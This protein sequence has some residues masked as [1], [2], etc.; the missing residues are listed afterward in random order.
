MLTDCW[1]AEVWIL[2]E[3]GWI[4]WF[5]G[6]SV[7]LWSHHQNVAKTSQLLECSVYSI[8]NIMI[9]RHLQHLLTFHKEFIAF[10]YLKCRQLV[11]EH[12]YIRQRQQ[13]LFYDGI[14]F[15]FMQ[16]CPVLHSHKSR[17]PIFVVWLC[18]WI[19]ASFPGPA[20]LSVASLLQA[21]K[22]WA[23]PG[24]EANWIHIHLHHAY[25]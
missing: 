12:S 15:N 24:N 10:L 23:G 9:Q 2:S 18:Y 21:T 8:K 22:S 1:V 3:L 16:Q 25:L 17:H 7:W 4:C 13:C 11:L 6:V 20:R 19:L 14:L 5:R